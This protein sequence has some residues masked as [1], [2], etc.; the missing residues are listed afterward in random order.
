MK[1]FSAFL[2]GEGNMAS[3]QLEGDFV[4]GLLEGPLDPEAWVTPL[5]NTL[6]EAG[7]LTGS[8]SFPLLVRP[9]GSPPG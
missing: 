2:R 4:R 1:R 5:N 9:T 3:C 8:P 6:A 7:W